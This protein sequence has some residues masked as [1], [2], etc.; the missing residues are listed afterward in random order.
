MRS[1]ALT[2]RSFAT[3]LSTIHA[4]HTVLKARPKMQLTLPGRF[5]HHGK[6]IWPSPKSS[7]MQLTPT[8]QIKVMRFDSFFGECVEVDE[9][10]DELHYDPAGHKGLEG[11][12]LLDYLQQAPE[13]SGPSISLESGHASE[14]DDGDTDEEFENSD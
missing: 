2:H 11:R 10:D 8:A 14:E 1:A 7:L 12:S 4:I 9:H 3:F 5:A 13:M 6:R